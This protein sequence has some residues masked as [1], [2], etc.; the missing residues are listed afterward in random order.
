MTGDKEFDDRLRRWIAVAKAMQWDELRRSPEAR[1]VVLDLGDPYGDHAPAIME[2]L[3]EEDR[4]ALIQCIAVVED[5]MGGRGSVTALRWFLPCVQDRSRELLAWVLANTRSYAHY[6]YG[7]RSLEELD[8]FRRAK[9]ERRRRSLEME[10]R[11]QEEARP[12]KAEQATSRLYNAVRRGDTR[13]VRALLMRGAD[14]TIKT[15]EGMALLA[16]ARSKGLEDIAELLMQA[17]LA[18]GQKHGEENDPS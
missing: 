15:P 13:A 12:R 16:F 2:K 4:R 5:A 7:A 3:T 9:E 8:E 17:T 11:R 14:A 10:R 18:G 6:S 1:S